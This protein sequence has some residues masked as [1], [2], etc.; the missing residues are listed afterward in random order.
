MRFS[1]QAHHQ[2]HA[3]LALEEFVEFENTIKMARDMTSRDDTLIIVT[4]DHSHAMVF[5]GYQKRGNDILDFANKKNASFYETLIYASGPGHYYH[6]LNDTNSSLKLEFMSYESRRDPLYMHQS[7]IPL[8]DAVHAA[9][10]VPVYSDG[11]NSFLLQRV[12]EQS[13]IPYAISYSAC[14]GPVASMNPSCISEKQFL[15]SAN[16]FR[17]NNTLYLIFSLFSSFILTYKFNDFM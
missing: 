6:K 3:R 9:D 5:N 16:L 13:Y 14:F 1:D 11:P 2:N 17:S 10:D 7:L 15:N 4:A 8:K 12:F